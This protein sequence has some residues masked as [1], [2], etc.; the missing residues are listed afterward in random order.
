MCDIKLNINQTA[1]STDKGDQINNNDLIGDIYIYGC[2]DVDLI[3]PLKATYKMNY[4]KHNVTT[5]TDQ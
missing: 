4:M 5:N 1:N 3:R 2:D